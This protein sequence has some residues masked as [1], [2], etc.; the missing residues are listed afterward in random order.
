MIRE[1][2][3]AM[4]LPPSCGVVPIGESGEVSDSIVSFEL[5]DA[6]FPAGVHEFPLG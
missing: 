5:K 4:P 3:S 6:V 1:K 2:R